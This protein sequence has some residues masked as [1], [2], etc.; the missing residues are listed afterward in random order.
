MH[1]AMKICQSSAKVYRQNR[2]KMA[3]QTIWELKS[4]T[5]RI[6]PGES[7]CLANGGAL[8]RRVAGA[9]R[10]SFAGQTRRDA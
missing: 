9:A 2:R 7:P 1:P 8:H 10:E 3:M 4:E 6:S 5:S